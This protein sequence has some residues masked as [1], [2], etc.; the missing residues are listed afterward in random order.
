MKRIALALLL[1]V[2]SCAH[3]PAQTYTGKWVNIVK[4]DDA[5]FDVDAS[6]WRYDKSDKT[7]EPVSAIVVRAQYLST[8]TT[9]VYQ[10][11]VPLK[12]CDR[13]YGFVN[14]TNLSGK[15]LFQNEFNLGGP[16]AADTIADVLCGL[17][18]RKQSGSV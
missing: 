3:A 9:S 6:S 7:H 2:A 18:R 8:H 12:D 17:H 5:I 16:T 14:S 11:F 10:S 4:T 13:G 15:F 1:F